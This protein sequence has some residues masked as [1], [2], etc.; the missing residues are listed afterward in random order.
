MDISLDGYKQVHEYV[1][2]GLEWSTIEENLEKVRPYLNKNF[3]LSTNTTVQNLNVLY[4][5]DIL[6]WTISELNITPVFCVLDN[7]K[8]LAVRNMPPEMKIEAKERLTNLINSDVVNNF[9]YP[10]WLAGR[11]T[12][13]IESIDLPADEREFNRFLY[14]TQVTDNERGQDYRISIPEVAS[15]YEQ[16]YPIK[17][18]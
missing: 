2:S 13:V 15:Y 5:A 17:P 11:I 14:F 3:V 9:K 4:L 1:R 8:W 12:S 18:I 16:Y 6:K 10:H 7:P